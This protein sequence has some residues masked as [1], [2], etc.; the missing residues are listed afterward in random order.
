MN[1]SIDCQLHITIPGS[2][3]PGK[4]VQVWFAAQHCVRGSYIFY[5]CTRDAGCSRASLKKIICTSSW[6]TIHQ[7]VY[8]MYWHLVHRAAT[9]N[10]C[11]TT[12]LIELVLKA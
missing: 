12:Q 6:S 9:M 1:W 2:E 8:S 10:R 3:R 5:M 11:I 4:R 7:V